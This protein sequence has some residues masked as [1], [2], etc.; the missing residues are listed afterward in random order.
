MFLHFAGDVEFGPGVSVDEKV[1]TGV[2]TDG[3]L[4]GRRI[5]ATKSLVPLAGGAS[6]MSLR[7]STVKLEVGSRWSRRLMLVVIA[8]K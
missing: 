3:Q 2:E 6:M 7:I 1:S 5:V 8:F 4:F